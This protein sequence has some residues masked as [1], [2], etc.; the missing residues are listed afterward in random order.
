MQNVSFHQKEKTNIMAEPITTTMILTSLA[1]ATAASG[2]RGGIQEVIT[3]SGN[4]FQKVFLMTFFITYNLF[5][6][7]DVD[8]GRLEGQLSPEQKKNLLKKIR[9]YKANGG[10]I[11]NLDKQEDLALIMSIVLNGDKTRLEIIVKTTLALYI[12][13]LIILAPYY[14][15]TGTVKGIGR[16]FGIGKKK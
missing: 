6:S 4:L 9:R 10:F 16:F 13:A 2:V 1:T 12:P 11:P 5:S 3:E 14:A 7:G 8:L 15:V